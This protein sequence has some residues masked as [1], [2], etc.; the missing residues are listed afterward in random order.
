[1]S[2]HLVGV[3]EVAEMLGVSRQRVNQLVSDSPDFPPPESELSAGR[4]WLR[5]SIEAWIAT[6]ASHQRSGASEE[7]VARMSERFSPDTRKAIALAGEEASRA[8]SEAIEPEHLLAGLVR[9]GEAGPVGQ[10]VSALNIDLADIRQVFAGSEREELHPSRPQQRVGR[11]SRRTAT[12]LEHA[13]RHAYFRSQNKLTSVHV[14]LALLSVTPEVFEA[15]GIE[16]GEREDATS[17][18]WWHFGP[19]VHTQAP[20]R[21]RTVRVTNPLKVR[22]GPSGPVL[23]RRRPPAADDLPAMLEDIR[24]RL[25]AIERLL[26]ER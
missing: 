3:A 14:L 26:D 5:E 9:L 22:V 8:G 24:A 11:F 15:L 21:A 7:A 2:H 19:R 6:N 23:S 16:L 4:V 25:Q 10:V 18:L 12:V 1:L 20:R 17:S 13:F